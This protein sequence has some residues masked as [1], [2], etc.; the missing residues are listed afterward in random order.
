MCGVSIL[1]AGECL[2]PA[3]CEVYKDAIIGKILIQTNDKTGEP[4]VSMS[5]RLRPSDQT[6][7][8]TD[9]KLESNVLKGPFR[10]W[11]PLF[12]K[13]FPLTLNLRET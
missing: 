2:E 4:E 11:V 12:Q 1:R 9:H 5:C 13:K 10:T 8:I 7:P 3:L 6:I